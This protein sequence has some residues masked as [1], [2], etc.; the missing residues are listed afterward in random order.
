[1]HSLVLNDSQ[2][3]I[4]SPFVQFG[5]NHG[6]AISVLH[7]AQHSVFTEVLLLHMSLVTSSHFV[8]SFKMYLS[9]TGQSSANKPR[10]KVH[11]S[12]QKATATKSKL[13][14]IK[15]NRTPYHL[16]L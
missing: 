16:F 10:Q 15:I 14:A 5:P 7:M 8:P 9:S 2:P 3:A 13:T 12:C 11:N 1:M 4:E 6:V